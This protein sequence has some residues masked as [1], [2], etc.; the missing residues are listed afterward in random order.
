[1]NGLLTTIIRKYK[2]IFLSNTLK[3]KP[4]DL[5]LRVENDARGHIELIG[6]VGTGV[7]CEEGF[8]VYNGYKNISIGNNVYLTDV[9]LNAGDHLG[10][11]LIGDN[12]FFG[13]HVQV[14]ARGHDYTK[15]GL[16]RQNTVIEKPV[17]IKEGV[18]VGSG[19]I[20]LPG[21]TIG[22]NSIIGAGSIVTKDVKPYTVVAGNPAKL[23]KRNKH[24]E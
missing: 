21:V 13:H 15:F 10:K 5:M 14:L 22:K 9:L 23:I 18:W 3:S 2:D 7:H 24:N 6:S 17:H 20:I 12:V 8:C 16:E 1:M 19:A 4:D 11:I